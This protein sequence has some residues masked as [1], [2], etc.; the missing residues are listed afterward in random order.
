LRLMQQTR[1]WQVDV[2][3][4]PEEFLESAGCR[5]Y[6]LILTDLLIPNGGG[7]LLGTKLRSGGY[8]NALIAV[9]AFDEIKSLGVSLWDMG[10]D[11]MIATSNVNVY[12]P[13]Y[14]DLILHKLNNYFYY[15]HVNKWKH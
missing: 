13:Q 11:G 15:R 10:F 3:K 2:F 12:T 6:D 9:T 8:K 14:L 1:N 7:M 5:S 4:N